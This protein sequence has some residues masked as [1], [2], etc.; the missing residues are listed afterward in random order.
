MAKIITTIILFNSLSVSYGQEAAQIFLSG[1]NS[2]NPVEWG[3]MVTKGMKRDYTNICLLSQK[4][5]ITNDYSMFLKVPLPQSVR[6]LKL[7]ESIP[8]HYAYILD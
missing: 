5:G 4:T 1:R 2:E 8:E 3:F 6:N 7:P